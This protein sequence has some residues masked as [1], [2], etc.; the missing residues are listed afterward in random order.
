MGIEPQLLNIVH[1]VG[2]P[3]A[4]EPCNEWPSQLGKEKMSEENHKT[5]LTIR[6]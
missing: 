1:G 6:H 2:I 3:Y 5:K 4:G